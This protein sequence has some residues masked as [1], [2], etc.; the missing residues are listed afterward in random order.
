M[1]DFL[2]LLRKLL[3][4]GL[5]ALVLALIVFYF[6]QDF[7]TFPGRGLYTRNP[8][9]W[10]RRV[11]SLGSQG[12]IPAEFAGPGGTTVNGIWAPAGPSAGPAILWF[13]SCHQTTT[14][15]N[16]DI[17]PLTQAGL[18]VFAME[19]RGY[20]QSTGDT[21]EANLLADAETSIE[22]M[23]K[24]ENVAGRRIFVGGVELGANLAIKVA[25]RNQVQGVVAINP[26]PDLATAV[27]GKIPFIPLGFLLRE[28]F[29][30]GADLGAVAV[31]VLLIHGSEDGVVPL[32]KIEEMVSRLGGPAP[33]RLREVPGGGQFD[34]L[35]RGGRDLIDDIERFKDRPR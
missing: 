33:A 21:T 7:V 14:E 28:K 34:T 1:K 16:Q 6:A 30:L 23:G 4:W 10:T 13:H 15:I 20:G 3:V 24:N 9:E 27:S 19:Y 17:K 11:A 12:C 31:P 29:D 25:A 26:L 22:W 32:A 8:S 5:I 18:H 35:E 2:K